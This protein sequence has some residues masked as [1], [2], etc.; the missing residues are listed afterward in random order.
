MS[1]V[2]TPTNLGL[3][4]AQG[5]ETPNKI[6][7]KVDGTSVQKGVNTPGV[8]SVAPPVL[9]NV[10]KTLTFPA[11]DGNTP[12]VVDLSQFTTDIFVSGGS[13]DAGTSVLT[14]TD[15][16]GTTGD[17]VVDLS[18]LLGVSTNAGNLLGNGTDGKPLFT[19]AN[20]D[21]QTGVCND[22]FG[23]DLF[24]GVNL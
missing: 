24:R 11:Q 8:L 9:D 18:T 2:V 6:T 14:L 22:A 13:F 20:L 15:N 3:E 17:I 16:D 1:Q 19:K 23:V 12:V 10:N 7:I 21:T 4:F 5:T